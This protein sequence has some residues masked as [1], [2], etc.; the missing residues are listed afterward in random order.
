MIDFNDERLV[1]KYDTWCGVMDAFYDFVT[2]DMNGTDDFEI[3]ES[4]GR[5]L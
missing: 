4:D 1:R 5:R 3:P 2:I